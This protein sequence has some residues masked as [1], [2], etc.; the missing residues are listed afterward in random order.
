MITP[1]YMFSFTASFAPAVWY[2]WPVFHSIPVPMDPPPMIV[3]GV[4]WLWFTI[5]VAKRIDQ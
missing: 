3:A 1:R 2:W 5:Y 4:S